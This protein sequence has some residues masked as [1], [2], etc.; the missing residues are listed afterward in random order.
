[1]P[2]YMKNELTIT[3]KYTAKIKSLNDGNINNSI[4]NNYKYP[5]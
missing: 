1:M 3:Y 4:I 5:I 2:I